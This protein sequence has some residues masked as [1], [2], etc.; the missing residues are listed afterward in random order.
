[1]SGAAVQASPE[2]DAVGVGGCSGLPIADAGSLS[3]GQ[4]VNGPATRDMSDRVGGYLL[5]RI[6]GG[7]QGPEADLVE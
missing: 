1:M 2:A 6:S 7:P 4:R 5:L 3:Q